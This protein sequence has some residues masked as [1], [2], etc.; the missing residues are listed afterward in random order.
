[1]I[2]ANILDPVVPGPNKLVDITQH[3]I[4]ALKTKYN[5]ADAHTHQRQS[6][7]QQ[8][9]ISRLPNL[10]YEAEE[11]LQSH[12]EQRFI[13]AFFELH[14]QPTALKKQK[15]LLAYAA[16]I[17]TMVP[18]V[19]LARKGL[20]VSLIEPCFDNLHDVLKN[21]GVRLSPFP[22]W[23]LAEPADI[24]RLLEQNVRTDAVFLVD[25]NNPTGTSLLKFGRKG[26]EEVV[27]FCK[28]HG[29]I[30]ILDLCFASFAEM[31]P[32]LGRFDLY[33]LLEGS[34]VSYIAIEDTGKTW[35]LQDTKC[36]LLTVS[37]DL[38]EEIYNIHTSVLLNVSPFVLN[39][40]TNYLQDSIRDQWASVRNVLNTNRES[41][42]RQLEGSL[43]EY[44]EPFV[45]VSVAW[46]RIADRELSA[47]RLQGMLEEAQVYVVPG[48]YFFWSNH[49]KGEQFVRM[50]LAREPRM[51][52]AAIGEVRRILDG[53]GQ[54]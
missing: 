43:L 34:K 15:T 37:D 48:T 18:A 51:F 24:Y 30:L 29:K 54:R 16:T 17:S 11:N 31:D 52:A 9:I 44:V 27:R 33:D 14:R 8:E 35:P 50:A 40:V 7:T 42:R 13:R 4:Q 41:A 32:K 19:F 6:P 26:F 21:M 36:S 39:L 25:P 10:W 2:A 46:F 20:T 22:E 38:F 23:L 53:H 28:D 49:S 3:E 12:F 47:T 45:N 5:L 1:M